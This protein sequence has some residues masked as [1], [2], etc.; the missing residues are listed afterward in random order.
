MEVT[1]NQQ[2]SSAISVGRFNAVDFINS[3]PRL[4]YQF[5]RDVIDLERKLADYQAYFNHHHTHRSLGG[6]TPAEIAGVVTNFQSS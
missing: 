6:D 2:S 4:E 1:R 5:A 3:P